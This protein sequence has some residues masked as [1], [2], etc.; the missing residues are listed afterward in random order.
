MDEEQKRAL[1]EEFELQ[2]LPQDVQA[3]VLQAMTETLLKKITLTIL[4]K[5]SEEDRTEFEKVREQEDALKTE[6]FLRERLPD[7]DALVD[8][9]VFEFKEEMKGHMEEI[10]RDLG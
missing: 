3:G 7:Y 2:D 1:L 10:K 4:E 9:V 8:G 5:L 6:S